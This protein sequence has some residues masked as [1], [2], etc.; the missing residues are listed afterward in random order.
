MTDS[1]DIPGIKRL[2][3]KEVGGSWDNHAPINGNRQY[4]VNSQT[5]INWDHNQDTHS[6]Y[7]YEKLLKEIKRLRT[8]KLQPVQGIP[9][10]KSY[11]QKLK[12]PRITTEAQT[13]SQ[14]APGTNEYTIKSMQQR[15]QQAHLKWFQRETPLTYKDGHYLPQRYPALHTSNGLQDLCINY[16]KWMGHFAN[17]TNNKGTARTK[18]APRFNLSTGKLDQ[19][20][21]GMQYIKSTSKKGMQD[22][23]CNL[24]HPRHEYGIPW[25]IEVK[26]K[27]TKDTQSDD[28]KSFAAKVIKTGAVYS[29]VRTDEDFFSQYDGLMNS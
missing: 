13:A 21:F 16:L 15:Y 17:R 18:Y 26:C 28:Q 24:K 22:I 2:I 19:I 4:L 1:L 25:K 9:L 20:I 8:N 10:R 23:D 3:W 12:T 29:L 27:T 11:P 7:E 14:I 6:L 5:N